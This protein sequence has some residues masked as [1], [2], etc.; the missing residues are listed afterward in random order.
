MCLASAIAGCNCLSATQY[1]RKSFSDVHTCRWMYWSYLQ[2]AANNDN[3]RAPHSAWRNYDDFNEY[4][5]WA[6]CSRCI[7]ELSFFFWLKY[8][9][10]LSLSFSGRSV[11]LSLVGLGAK[12]LHSSS[13]QHQ[14]QRLL[15]STFNSLVDD[16][17]LNVVFLL[18][19]FCLQMKYH[20][21]WWWILDRDSSP[22]SFS[23][24]FPEHFSVTLCLL[25]AKI[26][27]RLL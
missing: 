1:L 8:L 7:I 21:L 11:A 24:L 2:E 3:G 16:L 23:Y 5:W 17:W 26:V 15:T 22:L 27:W 19:M 25:F 6:L 10:D 12:V 18:F 20:L 9:L 4:F 13:S 14:G